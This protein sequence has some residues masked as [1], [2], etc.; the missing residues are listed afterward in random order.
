MSKRI[1]KELMTADEARARSDVNA[2]RK[3]FNILDG[4]QYQIDS[5]AK[6]GD[7]KLETTIHTGG[8]TALR[9]I[10]VKSLNDKGYIVG[11]HWR[12][13]DGCM[14]LTISWLPSSTETEPSV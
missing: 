3:A 1:L 10:I 6:A 4:L 8:S 2:K 11:V 5:K 7:Y 13:G 9:D 12:A 14:S